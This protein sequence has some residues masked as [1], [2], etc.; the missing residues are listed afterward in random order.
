V[1][2]EKEKNVSDGKLRLP[3]FGARMGTV[4]VRTGHCAA[5]MLVWGTSANLTLR[6]TS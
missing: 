2:R 1:R 4:S 3:V 6:N 5:H